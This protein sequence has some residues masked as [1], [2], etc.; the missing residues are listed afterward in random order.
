MRKRALNVRLVSLAIS[1]GVLSSEAE[2][3]PVNEDKGKDFRSGTDEERGTGA[4][5]DDVSKSRNE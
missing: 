5:T 2:M 1:H 3:S 4:E